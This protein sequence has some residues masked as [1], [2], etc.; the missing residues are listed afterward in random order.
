MNAI[1]DVPSIIRGEQ[2]PEFI[3]NEVLSDILDATAAQYPEHVAMIDQERSVTYAQLCK[4]ANDIAQQLIQRG[5][6]AGDIIGLWLPRGADLLIAQAG[7]CKA[8]AAWLPFDMDV[9]VDRIQVCLDDAQAAGIITS[10]DWAD[11]LQQ[12]SQPVWPVNM[13]NQ[14]TGQP[15][16][17]QRADL[18][19]PAY[20]IYT[21]GSTGKPKGIVIEQRNICHFLRSENS[22]LGVRHEDKVY[23]GFSVAFDMSFEEVWISYLVGATIWIAPKDLVTDPERLC[24]ALQQQNITVL[25]AVPTLLALFPEDVPNLRIIN[26]GGEMC[27]EAL[28]ARWDL[29]H[30]QIFNT[31]GP[32]ETTVTSSLARVYADE[33]V[34]IGV[35]LPNYGMLVLNDQFELLPQ[36]EVGELCVFGPS[37][38]REYLGRPE[39]TAEKFI[40]NTWANNEN[41]LKLYRTG[42]LARLDENDQIQCLGRADDQ[43]K[44]RGF[45]VELGEIEAALCDLNGIGTAAVVLRRDDEMDQLVAFIVLDQE[46]KHLIQV[47]EIRAYLKSRLPAYMIP[48]RFEIVE[49]VPRLL[50]GKIDRN[51]LRKIELQTSVEAAVSDEPQNEA[52]QILFDT[53]NK[54][55]PNQPIQLSAD[56]FDDLGGH[57]LLAAVLTSQLREYPQYAQITIQNI[58]QLRK[59]G[60]IS[61]F[62]LQ[63]AKQQQMREV[64]TY[65]INSTNRIRCGIAQFIVIPIL[66]GLTI[67]QWLAPFFSYHYFTGSPGDSTVRAMGI[68]LGVYIVSVM[69][70]FA[71]SVIGNRL[72]LKGIQPGQYP[73]WGKTYFRWWLADRLTGVAPTYLLA[74]STLNNLYLKALGAEIGHDVHMGSIHVRMPNLLTVG[75]GVSI[76]SHVNLENAKV[77]QGQLVLGKIELKKESYVGS[78]S[79][80]EENSCLEEYAHLKALS[81]LPNGKTIPAFEMWDGAPAQYSKQVDVAHLLPREQVSKTR[82]TLEVVYY[83]LSVVLISCLFF[84]PIFP[85]FILVDWFDVN[86][87]N[88]VLQASNIVST[89]FRYFLFAIPASAIMV[90]LTALFAALLRKIILPNLK[91]GTY[92]L[93][94]GTY[95]RKWFATQIF[96]TSLQTLHGLFATVYAPAWFR[97]MGAKVG[98]DSEVSTATGVVP[99]LLTLGDE[100]FIADA[101]MLG[102]EETTRGWMILQPTVIGCRSFVGNSAYI[103]DGTV[104]PDGVLIGVQSKIPEH[105]QLKSGETWFGSPALRLPARE[106]VG[107]YPEHLT[108]KPSIGR[109]MMRGLIEGLRIVLPLAFSIGMGY[110]IVLSVIAHVVNQGWWSGLLTLAVAGIGYGIASFLIIVLLKW[111]MIGRYQPRSTPMWTMFVWLSEG[112]TSLYESIAIPNCLNY[113]RGTPFLPSL[114]RLLGVKIGKNVYLDTADI[115]EFDCVS[116]GDYSELNSFSGPQTHLFEDRIMKIGQVQIGSHVTIHCRSIVLYNAEVANQTLL[117]PLTLVMKGEKIPAQSAWIGSPAQPWTN[118]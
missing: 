51:A 114:L 88:N 95:Y 64:T 59:V 65:E 54:I 97:L 11:S 76:G 22:V 1:I 32:T 6:K 27:P 18:A 83:A 117:G 103:A 98:R 67:L 30:H 25:H 82:K 66:I 24:K 89:A 52:E 108:F 78:Y 107:E 13:L 109:R 73:L 87:L 60:A 56:F 74:G 31:Y 9:P 17:A 15:S 86:Y 110:M 40:H 21:S 34:T 68:S 12:L 28:V 94:S 7:I 79:V 75:D 33:P 116:I 115:T 70:S 93:H 112:L 84:V 71:I 29:P 102:D 58:Y 77:E 53:L 8:G 100:S 42:D 81:A 113:V 3:R 36:G 37:V 55:F 19:D 91:P 44:V 35:P 118:G 43:V 80:I 106:S 85:S 50:S 4:Q 72:L 10:L 104:L 38:G 46:Q 14:P 111:V 45:R 41:E 5:I 63:Q 96:E 61:Q 49:Q 39:L 99:E 101:V 2:R 47:K 105:D 26:L 57:S 90:I 48:N 23:Q 62:M 92:S 16:V 20:I 69:L